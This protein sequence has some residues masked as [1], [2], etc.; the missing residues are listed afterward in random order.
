M[1]EC[2]LNI[3]I[4][5]A[6]RN[7]ERFLNDLA[8]KIIG[9][10]LKPYKW[11]IVDDGS[12]DKTK[13]IIVKLCKRYDWID[14]IFI[15]DRGFDDRG[16][17]NSK[18]ISLAFEKA[19]ED[20][21]AEVLCIFDADISFDDDAVS[22]ISS[23]FMK[24]DNLGIY[25]GEII[26]FKNGKWKSPVILPVDFVR[27]A[28]KAYR[29]KCYQ[30]IGGIVMRRGWD[31]IDNIKAS[32][33]GWRV[34][35]D[36]EFKVKHKRSVGIRDGFFRDQYKAGRDAYYIGSDYLLVLARGLAKTIK[37]RPYLIAGMVFLASFFGNM[38]FGKKKF[39]DRQFLK[40]VKKRH[41]KLLWE[42]F[43]KW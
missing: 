17:G 29:R 19:L 34:I 28:C 4:A 31:S 38:V 26:E 18:A 15:P 43:Y 35:R 42:G 22:R 40:F 13:D 24:D 6:V 27:G 1:K 25:G 33:K 10:N 11:V 21:F 36:F 39:S 7:E 30:Q 5:T 9:Q 32:M 37:C 16:R 12:T 41:R 14:S 23:N 3:F 20:G 8:K 2:K